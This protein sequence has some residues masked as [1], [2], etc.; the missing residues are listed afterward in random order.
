MLNK[1]TSIKAFSEVK[2]TQIFKIAMQCE[3]NVYDYK[4]EQ[5]EMCQHCQI[6]VWSVC[7]VSVCAFTV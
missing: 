2:C 6:H 1:P 4:H 5:C 7:I 3:V